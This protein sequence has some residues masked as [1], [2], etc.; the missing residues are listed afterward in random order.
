MTSPQPPAETHAPGPRE[1]D[2]EGLAAALGRIPSGLFV[3][4]WREE[5]RDR[6][7]LAS[8]VMQAGFAPPAVSV[9]VAPDRDL[10]GAL[11]R[12]AAVAINILSEPQRSV[13]AR[14]A[15]PA[16]AGE[17]PFAGLPVSRTP[18]GNAAIVGS[19][20][21][22]EGGMVAQAAGGDHTIV[23]VTITAAAAGSGDEP[24]VHTRRNGLRY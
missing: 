24:L 17:D 10:L 2:R 15:R 22:L 23:V 6:G 4:T 20:G 14:F 8:W 21:W 1:G 13:L 18:A 11:G 7:M 9:A 5:G 16:A 3:V 19:A 12:G